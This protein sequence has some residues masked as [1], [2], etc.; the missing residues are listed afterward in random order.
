MAFIL[1]ELTGDGLHTCRAHWG[2]TFA[3]LTLWDGFKNRR[4]KKLADCIKRQQDRPST[5]RIDRANQ[6][7]PAKMKNIQREACNN[8]RI[9]EKSQKK[10]TGMR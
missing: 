9:L 4:A 6:R 10:A 3:A 2:W 7:E 8:K 5:E 1:V